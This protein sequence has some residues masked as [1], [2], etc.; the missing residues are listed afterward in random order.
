MHG[1][2][3]NTTE[4][5]SNQS[6][7]VENPKE[8][9]FTIKISGAEIKDEQKKTASGIIA[10]NNGK[11]DE[12]VKS[13]VKD[14][15]EHSASLSEPGTSKMITLEELIRRTEIRRAAGQTKW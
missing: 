7:K 5:S 15:G 11:A 10:E 4:Y 8:E 2:G 9:C 13:S 3:S 14:V 1:N 6:T 12:V